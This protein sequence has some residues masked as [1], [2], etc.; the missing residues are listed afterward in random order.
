[1]PLLVQSLVVHSGASFISF[2]DTALL[3]QSSFPKGL[4]LVLVSL[5]RGGKITE[6]T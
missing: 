4:S 3:A 1:M 6:D 2:P 5:K